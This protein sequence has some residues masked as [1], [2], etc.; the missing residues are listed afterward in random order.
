MVS[1]L[2]DCAI[3]ELSHSSFFARTKN[4]AIQARDRE[5]EEKKRQKTNKKEREEKDYMQRHRKSKTGKY[6]QLP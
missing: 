2:K 1:F 3:T 4:Y 6:I 5:T